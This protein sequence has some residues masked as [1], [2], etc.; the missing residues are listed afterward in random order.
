MC[1]TECVDN[2]EGNTETFTYLYQ[3][4]NT[5]SFETM[6][7]VIPRYTC[8]EENIWKAADQKG[9]SEMEWWIY[10]IIA[11]VAILVIGGGAWCFI[12]DWK[13]KQRGG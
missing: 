13:K 8:S 9:A 11:V 7:Q 6:T 5:K 1:K 12:S 10:L 2:G 3:A 4:Y